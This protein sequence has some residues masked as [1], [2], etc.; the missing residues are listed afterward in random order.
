MWSSVSVGDEV[1]VLPDGCMDLL[2]DGHEIVD[3]R[4]RH[5]RASLRGRARL[6]DD[7][8]AFAPGYTPRV[9]GVPA[10]AF[11]DRAGSARRG[12]DAGAGPRR[13]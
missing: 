10:D 13:H 8:P 3:R 2:W 9:L 12:V 5:A 6:E 11:T 1:R 7:R 4:P